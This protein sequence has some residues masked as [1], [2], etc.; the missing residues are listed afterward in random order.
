[1]K[2]YVSL[3]V[4]L[5]MVIGVGVFQ[6]GCAV[7]SAKSTPE[8]MAMACA[9]LATA[10]SAMESAVTAFT[11]DHKMFAVDQVI[12]AQKLRVSALD[13][14]RSYGYW[15]DKGF[16]TTEEKFEQVLRT[17]QS[18]GMLP[19]STLTNGAGGGISG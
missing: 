17:V 12:T 1:M 15:V 5:F 7:G 11:K 2:K 18:A 14:A 10:Q 16:R 8:Q 19:S 3:L 9:D 13:T 6:V 4:V